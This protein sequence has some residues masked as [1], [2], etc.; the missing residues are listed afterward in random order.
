VNDTGKSI[1]EELKGHAKRAAGK[2][3]DDDELRHEGEAQAEKGRE[4]RRA[5]TH[6]TKAELAEARERMH[7][8]LK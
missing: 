5:D 7:Q 6:Q 1:T 3:L 4:E 8:Q 2:V